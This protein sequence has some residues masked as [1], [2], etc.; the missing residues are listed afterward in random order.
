MSIIAS[1]LR[2]YWAQGL[3]DVSGNVAKGVKSWLAE[4]NYQVY[5]PI[6]SQ[7]IYAPVG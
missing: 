5:S 2:P 1:S 4:E 6:K 3:N 7:A